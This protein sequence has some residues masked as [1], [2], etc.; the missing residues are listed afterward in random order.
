M[1]SLFIKLDALSNFHYTPRAVSCIFFILNTFL[2][3]L[4]GT[5]CLN[6]FKTILI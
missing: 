6:A 3:F 1:Q 2:R 4:N 5:D